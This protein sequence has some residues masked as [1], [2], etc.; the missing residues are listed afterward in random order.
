MFFCFVVK[1]AMVLYMTYW[2][3]LPYS[4]THLL[5]L[6]N[7]VEPNTHYDEVVLLWQA[8]CGYYKCCVI[9]R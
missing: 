9:C 7:K 8:S 5:I 4:V 1:S 3:C 6:H 2:G